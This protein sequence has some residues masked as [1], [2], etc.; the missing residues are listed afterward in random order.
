MV[1]E[2]DNMSQGSGPESTLELDCGDFS[3][4][5][6]QDPDKALALVRS[7]LTRRRHA[8]KVRTPGSSSATGASI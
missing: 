2:G 8:V 1:E 6:S 7:V 5:D 4:Y 3:Q